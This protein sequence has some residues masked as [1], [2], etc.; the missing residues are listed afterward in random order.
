MVFRSAVESALRLLKSMVAIQELKVR[1]N[2]EK[3]E[4]CPLLDADYL[5][6][7]KVAV[8]TLQTVVDKGP[9]KIM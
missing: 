3:C 4:T 7:F 2:E 6:S 8:Q 1:D 9:V 5:D